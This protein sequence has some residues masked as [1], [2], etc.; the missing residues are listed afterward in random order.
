MSGSTG[1]PPGSWGIGNDQIMAWALQPPIFIPD[2]YYRGEY[3]LIPKV[4]HPDQVG[5]VEE[6]FDDLYSIR[7][8]GVVELD[9]GFWRFHETDDLIVWTH[10]EYL[11]RICHLPMRVEHVT[12]YT[13]AFGAF[14]QQV[15]QVKSFVE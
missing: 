2:G 4:D 5:V 3:V 15:Q 11:K 7:Q 13:H 12:R 8:I 1:F 14:M 9:T 6:S 10:P